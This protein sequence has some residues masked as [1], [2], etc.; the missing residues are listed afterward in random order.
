MANRGKPIPIATR[1]EIKQRKDEP[2]R[3]VA[4]DLRLSVGTVHKYT[5][6]KRV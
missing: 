2:L 5:G 6:K 4:K 1:L 3:K